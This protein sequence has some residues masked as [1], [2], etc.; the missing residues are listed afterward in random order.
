MKHSLII[1]FSLA[2]TNIFCQENP[3]QFSFSSIARG[4]RQVLVVRQDSTFIDKRTPKE[5]SSRRTQTDP[6][7]WV[8]LKS[9][10]AKYSLSDLQN[11]ASPTNHRSHDGASISRIS[12]ST[13]KNIYQ[14]GEFD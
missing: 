11:L 7:T 9:S 3:T 4:S 1:F 14:C 5:T 8:R 12:I 13:E 2:L 10:I 6:A